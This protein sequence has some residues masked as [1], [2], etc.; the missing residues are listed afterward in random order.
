MLAATQRLPLAALVLILGLATGASLQAQNQPQAAP[1]LFEGPSI[2]DTVKY[3]NDAIG[4]VADTT[5]RFPFTGSHY[6]LSA[7]G[8]ELILSW[9]D[10]QNWRIEGHVY[11]YQLDC[12][13][14]VEELSPPWG[15]GF[16]VG[17]DCILDYGLCFHK[18]FQQSDGSWIE[19]PISLSGLS[20]PVIRDRNQAERLGK[21]LSHLI[22]LLQQEYKQSHSGPNDSLAK[23]Q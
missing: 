18:R 3:L 17:A 15:I 8:N 5:D 16:I 2:A 6:S 20:F 12:R 4:P 14:S 19:F 10:R 11:V 1:C 7:V 21:A 13:S 22:A 23:P 9:L